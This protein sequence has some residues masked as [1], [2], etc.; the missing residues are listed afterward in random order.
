MWYYDKAPLWAESRIM[1]ALPHLYKAT[2]KKFLKLPIWDAFEEMSTDIVISGTLWRIMRAEAIMTSVPGQ[3][4][5]RTQTCH[6][7]HKKEKNLLNK[8][9]KMNFSLPP[10][11]LLYL[12]YSEVIIWYLE[13]FAETDIKCY[14]WGAPVCRMVIWYCFDRDQDDDDG[15]LLRGSHGGTIHHRDG[16]IRPTIR[17][18]RYIIHWG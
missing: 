9:F 8:S 13:P 7:L 11:W 15:G 17:S 12:H 1:R 5:I 18:L 10:L 6:W 2:T 4:L 14:I 3:S 16:A